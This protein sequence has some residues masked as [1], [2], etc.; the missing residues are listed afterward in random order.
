[1]IQLQLILVAIKQFWKPALAVVLVAGA[2]WFVMSY[3]E[4]GV[5]LEAARTEIK[6]ATELA[7]K[8]HDVAI[9]CG[10]KTIALATA[11]QQ[12]ETNLADALARPPEVIVK[13]RDRVQVIHDTVLSDDCPTAVAQIAD[14]MAGAGYCEVEP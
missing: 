12:L 9:E 14:L 10:E 11:N 6:N 7:R 3:R 5:R 2:M 13:Y 4:R 8:W 1:M